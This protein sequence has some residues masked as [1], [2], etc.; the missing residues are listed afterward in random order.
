MSIVSHENDDDKDRYRRPTCHID[1]ETV[2]LFHEEADPDE[3]KKEAARDG[4][5]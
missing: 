5:I 3:S 2:E 4:V 1:K